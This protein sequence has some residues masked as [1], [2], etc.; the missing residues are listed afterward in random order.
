M[1]IMAVGEGE[2][3]SYFDWLRQQDPVVVWDDIGHTPSLKTEADWI[4][5][6]EI[7]FDTPIGL[8]SPPSLKLT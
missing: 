6:G 7:V 3:P 2:T 5:S 4:S 8:S 1:T